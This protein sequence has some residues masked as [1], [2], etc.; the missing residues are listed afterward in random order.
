MSS[1]LGLLLGCGRGGDGTADRSAAADQTRN[2]TMVSASAAT[3][4]SSND[5]GHDLGAGTAGPSGGG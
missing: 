5:A 3:A 4:D 2:D 1:A